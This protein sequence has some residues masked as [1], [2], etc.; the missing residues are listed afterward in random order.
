M[1]ILFSFQPDKVATA[2]EM[3]L[4]KEFKFNKV[5]SR[6]YCQNIGAGVNVEVNWWTCL[7]TKLIGNFDNFEITS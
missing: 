3:H 6:R 5:N 1:Q 7:K 2:A 4:E